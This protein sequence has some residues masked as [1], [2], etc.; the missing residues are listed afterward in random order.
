MLIILFLAAGWHLVASIV[1]ITGM[2]TRRRRLVQVGT[3]LLIF[4]F[5]VVAGMAVA[6]HL[7]TLPVLI[8]RTVTIFN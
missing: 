7:P 6:E 4:E 3:G 1:L 8:V 5:L 2:C